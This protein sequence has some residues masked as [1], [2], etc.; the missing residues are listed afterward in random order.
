MCVFGSLGKESRTLSYYDEL[1][2]D[3]IEDGQNEYAVVESLG[4]PEAVSYTH[5]DVYKRQ[6]Q[7]PI[8]YVAF[9]LLL[10]AL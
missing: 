5:L 1:I 10:S 9:F 2:D 4:S 3:R 8:V 7:G 6:E